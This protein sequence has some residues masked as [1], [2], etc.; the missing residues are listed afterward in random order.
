MDKNTALEKLRKKGIERRL[1]D[2]EIDN[3]VAVLKTTDLDGCCLA[4]W[5]EVATV[6]GVSR[7]AVQQKYSYLSWAG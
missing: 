4:T 2:Q 5:S 7:Q 6:L 1:L 3:L